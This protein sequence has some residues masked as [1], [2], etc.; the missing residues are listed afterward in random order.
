MANALYLS[1]P[2][3]AL[4]EG[5]YEENVPLSAIRRRGDFGLGTFNQLDGEMVM[6]DGQVF[7]VKGDGSVSLVDGDPMT[8]F[9]CVTFFKALAHDHVPTGLDQRGFAAF[10][11]SLFPSRN[12]CYA[13]RVDGSFA[14]V[15]TRSVPR[16]DN[17]RPLAEVAGEQPTFEFMDVE[18]T[19]AGFFT[20]S[21][22][23]SLNVPGLHLHFLSSD[24]RCGGHLL[25][26][27]PLEAEVGIQY[28]N[29]L[30]VSL[31]ATLD[32]L[33]TELGRDVRDDLKKAER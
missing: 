4:V 23:P 30:S 27:R 31:P 6:L 24:R 11:E 20:P 32:Y 8:P 7:Q 12:L 22:M 5:L 14:Y 17:Y 1:S 33:T 16:Q 26:C 10:L 2:V 21:F 25:E 13:I 18:G 28:L 3:N 19:L 29:E 15:K 9:A